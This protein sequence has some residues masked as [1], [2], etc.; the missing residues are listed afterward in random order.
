MN[1]M[2]EIRE[3]DSPDKEYRRSYSRGYRRGGMSMRDEE[4]EEAFNEGFECALD[5]IKK[6]VHK[7]MEMM[8]K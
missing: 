8:G 4:Y 6:A 5:T 7:E 3:G 1:R 2:W